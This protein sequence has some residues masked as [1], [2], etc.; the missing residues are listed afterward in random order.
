MNSLTALITEATLLAGY[1]HPCHTGH[2]WVTEGGRQCPRGS[3]QAS[4]VVYVC[5]RCGEQ[6]YGEPGGPGHSDCERPCDVSCQR[7]EEDTNEQMGEVI[8]A[9]L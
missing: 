7:A 9:L 3:E 5:A 6:D 8:E 2:A 1:G 4:Q